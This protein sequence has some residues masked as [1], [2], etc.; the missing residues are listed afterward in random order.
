[1]SRSKK[2]KVLTRQPKRIETA[3]VP[4]LSERVETTPPAIEAIPV[5]PTGIIVDL[6]I[7]PEPV[8]EKVP[9][10]LK[11]KVAILSKLPST[12]GTPR[13]RRMA[14]VLEAVLES[15]KT[16]PSSSSAEAS[17]S[18]T[19]E[20]PKIITDSTSTYTEAGSSEVVPEKLTEESLPEKP[21]APAPKHIPRV[22]WTISFDM[23]RESN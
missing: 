11:I 18:K 4:K 9:D 10:Q 13:K 1:V 3:E 12:T 21:S 6:T 2:T 19:E 16:P 17:G 5:L 7:E 20:I 15:V 23:L 22:T 8:T 14:S